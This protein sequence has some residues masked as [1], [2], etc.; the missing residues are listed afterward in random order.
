ME[1]SKQFGGRLFDALFDDDVHAAFRGSVG[2]S[3]R[4]G[5][6]LRIR[7]RFGHTP[8]LADI[9]WEYLYDSRA[10]RFLTL[11]HDAW[12]ATLIWPVRSSL[13]RWKR[14]CAFW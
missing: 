3:E 13:C 11:S 14:P 5:T 10:D 9:P 6:G 1:L 2:E 8:E 4:Q 12:Y 7:L